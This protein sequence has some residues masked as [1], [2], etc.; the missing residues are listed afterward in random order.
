MDGQNVPQLLMDR[1]T[2]VHTLNFTKYQI[3]D[4]LGQRYD[5]AR[6]TDCNVEII[7]KMDEYKDAEGFIA[8][9]GYCWSG[10][11][12]S[13]DSTTSEVTISEPIIKWYFPRF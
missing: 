2:A 4:S 1:V 10:G 6:A 9:D 11:V 5:V 12:P 13:T 7:P 3:T 8:I